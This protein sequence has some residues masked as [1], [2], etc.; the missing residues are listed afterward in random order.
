MIKKSLLVLAALTMTSVIAHADVKLVDEKV[1]AAGTDQNIHYQ[2]LTKE[3]APA[4][5]AINANIRKSLLDNVC[6]TDGND[7]SQLYYDGTAKVRAANENYVSYQISIDYYCG[8]AHPDGAIY[9]V[10][11]DAKTGATVD[12]NKEVP[13][14][15]VDSTTDFSKLD[16]Y[17]KALA[18]KMLAQMKISNP[19]DLK[20]N[21]CLQGSDKE[22][23]TT[24]AGMY[25]TLAGLS[26]GKI[27]AAVSPAHVEAACGFEVEMSLKEVS[28]FIKADSVIRSWLKPA[29]SAE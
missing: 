13:V 29:P 5:D 22:I 24:I 11:S 7:P 9:Y 20:G 12:M 3:E 21:D 16:K 10:L 4:A 6:D 25:P 17:Q 26:D 18:K 23:V 28:E 19:A 14:Q 27:I 1:G 2:L 15:N 8:G